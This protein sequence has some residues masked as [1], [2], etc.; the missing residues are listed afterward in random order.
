VKNLPVT[1]QTDF[2]RSRECL[3]QG[4]GHRFNAN[5]VRDDVA[6]LLMLEVDESLIF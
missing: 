2:L 1:R 3:E 6:D 4:R 5:R